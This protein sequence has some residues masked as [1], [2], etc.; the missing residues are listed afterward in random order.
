MAVQLQVQQEVDG[1]LEEEVEE[2]EEG[3][4]VLE[5]M[6]PGGEPLSY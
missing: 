2:V 3:R 6:L 1:D 4:R 5:K